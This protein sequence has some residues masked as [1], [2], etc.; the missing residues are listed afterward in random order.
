MKQI[1]ILTKTN[2]EKYT[3]QDLLDADIVI[4]SFQFLWNINYYVNYGYL[5]D[6]KYDRL[7]KSYISGDHQIKTRFKNIQN[8]LNFSKET[9]KNENILFESV[10]WHRIVVDEAHE[11]FSSKCDYENVY[12]LNTIKKYHC[13]NKWYVSGTPFYDKNSLTNVMN[14]LDFKSIM[15]D[16]G[17]SHYLNLQ[18]SME[19]GLS[20]S[21]ILNSIFKQIYIRNTKESVKDELSIP[22]ANIENILL[23][24]SEFE[25]NLYESLKKYKDSDYLR[26]IC[27]NIQICDKFG[28]DITSILNFDE[29]KEKLITDN[30]NKITKTEHSI[31]NLDPMVPGYAARKKMLE[32][33]ILSSKYLLNC[34][35][36]NI[37]INENNCPICRC[38]FDDPIVTNCGHNFCYECI[39]EVL[40]MPSYKN[41]CPMCRTFISASQI[42]KI[43]KQEKIDT[44]VIDQL[45]YNYGTK[46]AKLIKLCNQ[47]LLNP[48]TNIIIFSEWDKLLSMIGFVLKNNNINNVF[49]KGNVH[50]RNAAISAFRKDSQ[51]KKNKKNNSRVIMLSTEHA[52]SGTNLTEATHIIFMEPHKGEYGIV[53]A[54]EDQAIGR[55]VRLGQENQVNVYRLI[56]KDTIEEEIINNFLNGLDT[57]TNNNDDT[58]TYN[59][60]NNINNNNMIVNI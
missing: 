41:E 40:Q 6:P 48:N 33:I 35:S 43:E 10:F 20:E 21:N 53:K 14:F 49:C 18:E 16:N 44:N 25:S 51:I 56:M 29:V 13:S 36:S 45:V 54:M 11:I 46:L 42:Y 22:S 3:F 47:I 59:N 23:Q 24:F 12:L 27:C 39:T 26:Q 38:E 19:R 15:D 31:Y 55:A 5:K 52:A 60:N 32:N 2:H 37:K 8:L 17:N 58:T 57:T 50:Q 7:T 1:L 34:F 9:I 28:S 4:T 30:K